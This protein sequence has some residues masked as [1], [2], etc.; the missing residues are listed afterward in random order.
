MLR[1][2]QTL[3]KPCFSSKVRLGKSRISGYGITAK[4]N[5][6]R[7]EILIVEIG[8][9]VSGRFINLVEK[10]LG[11]ECELC[12]GRNRYLL[13]APLHENY[14]GGYINHS[15]APNVGML[16]N[17]VWA[18]ISD[19]KPGEEVCCD[20][21]TFETSPRWSMKC[22]CGSKNCRKTITYKDYLISDLI[23]RLGRW[24]APYLRE[25]LKLRNAKR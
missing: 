19:I 24:Y 6:K 16:E 11:Y 7:G 1:Y 23:K 5:I 2:L 22:N 18:A 9:I 12:V 4:C 10:E 14:Q 17:G 15:C 13:H 8:P 21:G 20:Y 3:P 25:E